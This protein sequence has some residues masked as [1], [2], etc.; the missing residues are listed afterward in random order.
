M[1]LKIFFGSL[2]IASVFGS[3]SLAEEKKVLRTMR[4][5]E[6]YSGVCGN[7]RFAMNLPDQ[8]FILYAGDG[9]E[10]KFGEPY[11]KQKSFPYFKL[12][13]NSDFKENP[14]AELNREGLIIDG[15]KK[16]AWVDVDRFEKNY[17]FFRPSCNLVKFEKGN[18]IKNS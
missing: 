5:I 14:T 3:S 6:E 4:D 18:L 10:K 7:S 11:L 17:E 1:N 15:V 2:L 12:Y 16:C 9:A 8:D 13:G